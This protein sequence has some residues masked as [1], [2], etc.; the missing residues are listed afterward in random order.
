MQRAVTL[1]SAPRRQKLLTQGSS[2]IS[3]SV[4]IAGIGAKLLA[5]MGYQKG[6]GLG[7]NKQGIAT[8]IEV[9]QRAKRTGLGHGGIP[10]HKL[11]PDAELD[12]PEPQ[13][14]VRPGGHVP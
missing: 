12:A 8:A 2:S 13:Q 9:K 10:E 1:L 11:V 7:R 5:K 6:E 4:L 3:I 14:Q